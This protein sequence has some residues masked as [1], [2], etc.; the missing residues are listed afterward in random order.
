MKSKPVYL[1]LAGRDALYAG[2]A[3]TTLDAADL[4]A[5]SASR[6]IDRR[7]VSEGPAGFYIC[8]ERTP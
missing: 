8:L 5:K 3:R 6:A 1:T 7:D 4:A 2:D